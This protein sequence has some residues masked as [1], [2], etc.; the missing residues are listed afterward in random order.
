ML[1]LL[2]AILRKVTE[3]RSEQSHSF[4]DTYTFRSKLAKSL[5]L[6]NESS[7]AE[8]S[9]GLESWGAVR[10]Q[11]S[12]YRGMTLKTLIE[13]YG[14]HHPDYLKGPERRPT[15]HQNTANRTPQL[16]ANSCSRT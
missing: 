6:E 14:H 10:W 2:Q 8:R 3:L 12:E 4:S 5:G 15:V 13:N 11:A 9:S 1:P 16:D 7:L